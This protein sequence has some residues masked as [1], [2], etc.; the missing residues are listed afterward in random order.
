M[1]I[2]SVSIMPVD[3][4]RL[5]EEIKKIER[6][7]VDWIHADIMDGC[8]VPNMTFGP[9]IL[10]AVKRSTTLPIHAHLM[11]NNP[12]RMLE[13]FADAGADWLCVH[14]ES[15]VHISRTIQHIKELDRK[16]A[17]ALNP[18]TPLESIE[19]LLND[20]DMVI[21]M[22]VNPGFS[23]QK[24]IPSVIPKISRLR[25]KIDGLKLPVLIGV[26][27]GVHLDTIAVLAAAG[28]DVFVSGS[29]IFSGNNLEENIKHLKQQIAALNRK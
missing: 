9:D 3:F 26:D 24:L 8:F 13:A 15:A 12:D 18:A 28:A 25:E 1:G 16:A 4:G 6:A 11:I 10:R 20:V 29:E 19:Y 21:I 5:D 14:V 22:T 7:G 17:I 27:G 23:G 2:L